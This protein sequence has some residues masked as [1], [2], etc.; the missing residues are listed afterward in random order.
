MS[1]WVSPCPVS[2]W[3]RQV[4]C[5]QFARDGGG[6]EGGR[7]KPGPCHGWA[8]SC[9]RRTTR[10]ACEKQ[11]P[12]KQRGPGLKAARAPGWRGPGVGASAGRSPAVPRRRCPGLSSNAGQWFGG[13]LQCAPPVMLSGSSASHL[14]DQGNAVPQGGQGRA[15]GQ[16]GRR[17]DLG[18]QLLFIHHLLVF[19]V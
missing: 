8:C 9:Q 4:S 12:G 7:G 18:W 17:A 3:E 5:P 2:C 19:H 16:R 15:P 11:T 13:G 14:K 10:A 6:W 1:G